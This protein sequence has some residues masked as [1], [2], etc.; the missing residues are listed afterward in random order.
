MFSYN[1]LWKKLIDKGINKSNFAKECNVTMPTISKMSKNRYVDMSTLDKICN[2]L[3]CSIEDII[4]HIK[5]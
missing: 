2:Y 4:E 1:P 3:H 5:D